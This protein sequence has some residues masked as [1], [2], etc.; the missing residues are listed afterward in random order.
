M[1]KEKLSMVGLIAFLGTCFQR[2][3]AGFQFVVFFQSIVLSEEGDMLLSIT[4]LL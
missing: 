3:Y 2:G 1:I 4:N